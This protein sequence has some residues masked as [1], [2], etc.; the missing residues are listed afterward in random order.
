MSSNLPKEFKTLAAQCDILVNQRKLK[1]PE[2]EN[3]EEALS[4]LKRELIKKNYFDLVN[5][6]EDIINFADSKHKYY[7]EYS[8]SDLLGL[9]KLNKELRE[10]LLAEISEFEIRLKTSIAYHFSER[11][12]QWNDYCN[13]DN[14]RR[15]TRNDSNSIFQAR[16]GY[17]KNYQGD[18]PRCNQH[19]IFPFFMTDRRQIQKLKRRERYM[20]AYGGHPPLWVAIKILDFGQLHIMFSLLNADVAA[21]VLSEFDFRPVS[22]N[23]FESVLYVLNWLRNECAHFEMINNSRYHG[24]VPVDEGLIKELNLRTNRSRR[25]LNLFQTM[26]V[27]NSVQEFKGKF[28]KLLDSSEIDG[29]LKQRYLRSIGFW[30][31]CEWNIPIDF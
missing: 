30:R 2:S 4:K 11:Y 10:L 7:G 18:D 28:Y 15:V 12:S 19:L 31:Q 3:R 14:Y 9:Y 21:D 29:R 26:C 20:S 16:Y 22:R 24:K 13:T 17:S 1:I 27:L 8:I 23:K 6:L 5:G 25:N